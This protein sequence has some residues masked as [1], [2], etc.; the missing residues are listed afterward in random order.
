MRHLLIALTL[1]LP[2]AAGAQ[3]AKEKPYLVFEAGGHTGPIRKLLFTPDGKQLVS[4][5]EDKTIRLWGVESGQLLKVFRPPI[6][7]GPEGSLYAAALSPDGKMLAV[8]GYGFM[9]DQKRYAPIYLIDLTESGSS[10]VLVNHTGTVHDL[11]FTA[12]GLWLASVSEDGSACIW[13]VEKG[14]TERVFNWPGPAGKRMR[15]LAL[16]PNGKFIAVQETFLTRV[17]DLNDGRV[18]VEG[19]RSAGNG[20][21]GV[22]A[23][24]WSRDGRTV[25]T[26]GD[27]GTRFWNPDGTLR[28]A[29]PDYRYARYRK[30]EFS[31]D[32]AKLLCDCPD[33]GLMAVV[34]DSATGKEEAVF[35]PGKG[36]N[37]AT[38]S[39]WSKDNA[40]IATSNVDVPGSFSGDRRT[41]A[42]CSTSAR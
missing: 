1:S 25:A 8:A 26:S 13:N 41:G 12:D 15:R 17:W 33:Y 3:E 35:R 10:R 37:H 14:Q 36:Q 9:R 27:G 34:L 40:L 23:L 5:S 11:G 16:S 20:G 39:T 28:L 18:V 42:S 22:T 6:G 32:S 24:A 7:P 31:R 19:F 4:V 21:G 38:A 29:L 30:L 2:A